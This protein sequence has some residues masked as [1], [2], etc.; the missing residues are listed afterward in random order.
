MQYEVFN[1]R[2]LEAGAMNCKTGKYIALLAEIEPDPNHHVKFIAPFFKQIDRH[3]L[4]INTAAEL[5][6]HIVLDGF[7]NKLHQ[8][9]WKEPF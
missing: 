3:G 2:V 8:Y 5:Y 1:E 4:L 7:Y 9:F 6:K